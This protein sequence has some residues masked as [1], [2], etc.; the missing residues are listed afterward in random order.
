MVKVMLNTFV[1]LQGNQDDKVCEWRTSVYSV[2]P[3]YSAVNTGIYCNRAYIRSYKSF[4]N[5]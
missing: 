3:A 4:H 2:K 5:N 1:E